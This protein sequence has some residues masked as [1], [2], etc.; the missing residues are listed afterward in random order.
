MNMVKAVCE[1]KD[2]SETDLI[3]AVQNERFGFIDIWGFWTWAS[4]FILTLLTGGFWLFFVAGYHFNDI[5]RP[6]YYCNQCNA[7]IPPKQFR[8]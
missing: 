3:V 5:V 4:V 7:V 1:C 6:K 2:M 8:L